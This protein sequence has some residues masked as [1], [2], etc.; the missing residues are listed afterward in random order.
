MRH[1]RTL[2]ARLTALAVLA[3]FL[4]ISALTVAF[5]IVLASNLEGDANSRLRSRAAAAAATVA[6]LGGRLIVRE[7][8]DDAALD[9]RVWIYAGRRA[10]ERPAARPSLQLAADALAGRSDVFDDVAGRELRLYAQPIRRAGRQVG[11]VVA[12]ESLAAYDR[13]ADLALV[14]SL[15]LGALLLAAMGALSWMVVGR[16]LTPVGEMTRTAADWSE[17]DPG[18]RFGAQRRSDELGALA[19]TFDG[20]LD[21]VAASIRN[22]QRLSAELSHELRTP[23]ARIVAE[24]ELLQRRERPAPERKEALAAVARSAEQMSR[25]LETLMA[26]ARADAGLDQGRVELGEALDRVAAEWEPALAESELE[27]AL[28]RPV[29]PLVAGVEAEVVERILAPLLENAR[30]MARGRV[31][32]SAG[33]GEEGVSVTVADDGPGVPVEAIS[34]LFEPGMTSGANGHAGAGLGLPLARRL[35]RAAGGDVVFDRGRGRSG[36]VFRVDLPF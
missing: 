33:R 22:E 36:A 32:L 7:S 9:Q 18:R 34:H 14:G 8:P 26:A 19:R 27:L 23:L 17:H 24:V 11:T 28:E 10:V 6:S 31:V 35:A 13:T 2:R 16:A 4:A 1:F 29:T 25:I 15:L 20:L 12:G 21:R 30:R 3:A 5:N